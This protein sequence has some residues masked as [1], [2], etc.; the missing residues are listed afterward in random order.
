MKRS[1]TIKL[2]LMAILGTTVMA[3]VVSAFAADDW[4]ARLTVSASTA[5][6]RLSFGQRLGATDGIDPAFDVPAM[7]SGDIKASF[8]TEKGGY[9]RD[10]RPHGTRTWKVNVESTLS[11]KT[12]TIKWERIP[13]IGKMELRDNG[14][15]VVV[16]MSSQSSYTYL[17]EGPRELTI[18]YRP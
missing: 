1:G 17:N 11:G 2:F 8:K 13:S 15:G 12:V 7:L 9:W 3:G 16:D 5:S 4:E 10:I 18:E 14:A 6:N